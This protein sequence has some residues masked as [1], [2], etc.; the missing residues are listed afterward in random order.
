MA[1]DPG[2]GS[3]PVGTTRKLR[4]P[5]PLALGVTSLSLALLVA[6]RAAKGP[7]EAQST[8][9]ARAA[10]QPSRV[11]SRASATP[12]SSQSTPGRAQGNA[13]DRGHEPAAPEPALTTSGPGAYWVVG[14]PTAGTGPADVVVDLEHP[15]QTWHGFGGTFNEAGWDALQALGEPQRQAALRLLFD[16]TEGIGLTWG[17]IP[18]GAS[19]FALQRYTLDDRP[20]PD[21]E[22]R[23]S[24][25]RDE[26]RLIPYLKAAQAVKGD[27]KFWGSPWTPPPW[28]K[29]NGQYDR[30]RLDPRYMPEMASYLVAWIQGYESHQIPIDHVQPQNE[31]GYSQAY[32]SCAWGPS[33]ADGVTTQAAVTLGTFVEQHLAPAIAAAGLKTGIW[34]GTLSNGGTFDAYWS[35]LSAGGRELIRGVGLQWGTLSRARELADS[36]FLVMQT[37]HRCGNYPWLRERATSPEDAHRGNFLADRA[38][39]NHAYAEESWSLIKQWIEAGANAYNAWNMV[40]DTRGFNLDEE[41]PWPQNALLTVDKQE[42]KLRVTPAYYVFRHVGQ[43]VDPGAVRLPTR[44]GDALS[45]RNPDGSLVTILF[46][47]GGESAPTTL[48]LGATLVHVEVPARGWATVNWQG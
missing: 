47:E 38:P 4:A 22:S 14:E 26:A 19:D 2:G 31:P 6:C 46:N 33:T 37:E 23:F 10:T 15:L 39:N 13:A 16:R 30:G 44:G 28:M 8:S 42:R 12:A 3:R 9:A 17:R 45:F 25:A 40:L 43:Y 41:R 35:G 27:I 1:S 36:G 18:I 7:D 24:L 48:S 34:Y 5:S 11:A 29:T 20:G 32:P 21:A